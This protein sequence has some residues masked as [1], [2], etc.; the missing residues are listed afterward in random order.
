VGQNGRKTGLLSQRERNEVRENGPNT[1]DLLMP[2]P[3]HVFSL[4]PAH[5]R[6]ER[7]NGIPRLAT[8]SGST[9]RAA[10]SSARR[11]EAWASA[12]TPLRFAA[13]RGEDIALYHRGHDGLKELDEQNNGGIA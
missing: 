9:S 11:G 5:S 13:R 4:T 10:L 3:A 8:E 12:E 6:W 2:P 1:H 7:E